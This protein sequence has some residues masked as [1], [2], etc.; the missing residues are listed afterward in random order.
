[1]DDET[2]TDAPRAAALAEGPGPQGGDPAGTPPEPA[3]AGPSAPGHRKTVVIAALVAS[4]FGA[5][6]G[7]VVVAALDD[8]SSGRPAGG[9][10]SSVITHEGDVQSILEK[11]EPAVVSITTEVVAVDFLFQ[12]VPQEGAGTGVVIAPDGVIVTNNH[13]I[14]GARSVDVTFAD[15][16]TRS[17]TVLGRDASRDL[18]VIKVEADGLPTATLGDSDRLRVG[19]DVV[20]I[21][22]ALALEGGPTVTRG[23]VSAKNRTIQTEDGN[24]LRNLLQTDTAINPGNSGGPLVDAAGEVVGINT[25]IAGQAQNIGF[26]ISVS[27]ARAIIDELRSGKVRRQAQ[28]GVVPVEITPR[29]ETELDLRVS[30]GVVV[31]DVADGSGA[32]EAGGRVGDVLISIGGD[33]VESVDD[34]FAA[35]D[36]RHPGD[37]VE[38]VVQRGEEKR[39]M[40]ATLGQRAV[41]DGE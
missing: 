25:A 32:D 21:G 23:I 16:A 1:M 39:T 6:A 41:P 33:A 11:V 40:R 34:V 3:V 9:P 4:L 28:L 38:L 10:N 37:E 15:G 36:R 27:D 35:I 24:R 8:D 26:A 22:N 31:V 19:D 5:A 30:E 2:S 14:D 12:P 20:A 13:V 17:A 29:L 7:G 18:A